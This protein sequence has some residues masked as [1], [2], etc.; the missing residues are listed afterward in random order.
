MRNIVVIGGGTGTFVVLVGLKKYTRNLTA[1]VSVTDSGGSSGILRD[2]LGVLPPGD[3][4]RCLV[5]LS[6]SDKLMRDLFNYR[7]KGGGLKGHSFG[8]LFLSA[9]EKLTG[10]FKKAVVEAS[11]ILSTDGEVIPVANRQTN[12]CAMLENGQMIKGE[13]NIDIP[14]H[15][16]N[17]KI[18]KVWLQ[19]N[20]KA[21]PQA[22]EAIKKAE[23]IVI[24]PGD[25][26]TSIIPNLLIQG[27]S[28]AIKNSK[29]KKIYVC[30]LMTKFGETNGFCVSDFVKTMEKYLG[31]NVIDYVIFNKGNLPKRLLEKYA[32]QKEF[33]VR[34]DIKEGLNQDNPKY[35]GADIAS[36][37]TL[38]RH[39][40]DKLAK[41][42]L[43]VKELESVLNLTK[44]DKFYQKKSC[45]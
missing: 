1:I 40:P 20:I 43:T 9:L 7:F 32:S 30:N 27:L 23:L 31:R 45:F 37:R 13:A 4:R 34:C 42:I 10:S 12:L 35:L 2:E 21:T 19:P 36:H 38:I 24:G 33:P 41:L 16:G 18:K 8:N 17:L 39:H 44:N 3:I 14:K 15:D 25:L 5:A 11:K 26:Y 22:L 28:K 29:A 6:N